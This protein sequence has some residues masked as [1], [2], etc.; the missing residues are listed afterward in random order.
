M[1]IMKQ[2]NLFDTFVYFNLYGVKC[3][4]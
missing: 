3:I 4:R 2:L 1:I